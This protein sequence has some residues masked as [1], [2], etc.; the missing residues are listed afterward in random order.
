MKKLLSGATLLLFSAVS[1][2][3]TTNHNLAANNITIKAPHVQLMSKGDE[4]AEVFMS[5][6]NISN[7]PISLIAANSPVATQVQLRDSMHSRR[8]ESNAMQQIVRQ[9]LIGPKSDENLQADGM[10]LMLLGL[11]QTLRTGDTI[12]VLLIFGDG[13]SMTVK[14]TVATP[15]ATTVG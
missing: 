3:A 11:K 2:A 9:I 7:R 15:P 13:S 6:D 12:P 4:S 5:L 10:H 8:S 14:A 1:G